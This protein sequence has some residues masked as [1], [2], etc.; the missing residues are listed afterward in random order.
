MKESQAATERERVHAGFS[1]TTSAVSRLER[2]RDAAVNSLTI[3][4]GR[5]NDYFLMSLRAGVTDDPRVVLPVSGAGT[6]AG[7]ER[8]WVS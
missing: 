3:I 1:K 8:R 4:S 7:T 6:L 2:P 5:E